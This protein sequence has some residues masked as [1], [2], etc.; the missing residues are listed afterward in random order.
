MPEPALGSVTLGGPLVHLDAT[1]IRYR[2][3]GP[4]HGAHSREILAEAAFDP[5]RI[6]ALVAAGVV[7]A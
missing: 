3:L 4:G 7:K 5:A 6:A 1:P 2:R